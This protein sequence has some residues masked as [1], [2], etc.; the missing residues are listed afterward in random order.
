MLDFDLGGMFPQAARCLYSAWEGY[1]QGPQWETFKNNL[2]AAGGDFLVCHASGHI[3]RDGLVEFVNR[4]NPGAVIPIH[5][6]EPK[7][8]GHYFA[9][10]HFLE[11]GQTIHWESG[12][13]AE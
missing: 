3:F 10:V 9:N 6:M 5:T 8:F 11:D 2:T 12:L 13:Q 1:L 7:R 4:V